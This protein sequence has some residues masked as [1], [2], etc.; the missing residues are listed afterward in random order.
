MSENLNDVLG[1]PVK[2]KDFIDKKNRVAYPVKMVDFT[3][4][5]DNFSLINGNDL[6]KNFVMQHSADA[7][8]AV[9]SMTFKDDKIEDLMENINAGNFKSIIDIIMKIN[10]I[11][12]IED[13]EKNAVEV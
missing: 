8:K 10:G 12:L 4:F 6:W 2:V 7:L 5:I 1:L 9:L 3:S 11:N 13:D